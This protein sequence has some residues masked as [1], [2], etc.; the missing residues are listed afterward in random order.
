MAKPNF[1][2]LKGFTLVELSIVLVIFGLIVG[3]V[4]AGQSLI[5]SAQLRGQISQMSQFTTAVSAFNT[6]FE[7][8]PGDFTNKPPVAGYLTRTQVAGDG[9]GNGLIES[10][11]GGGAFASGEM[12]IFWS[13]LSVA[14]LV[15]FTSAYDNS[16]A[17]CTAA[18]A[19][20][21]A[22]YLPK[23]AYGH[24]NKVAVAAYQ[25][26]N[27]YMVSALSSSD[28]SGVYSG[29]TGIIPFDAYT[30]DAKLDD[31]TPNTGT[32]VAVGA[33]PTDGATHSSTGVPSNCVDDSVSPLTY[34]MTITTY[35]CSLL[36]NM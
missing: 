35:E 11:C 33:T 36:H 14:G 6:K 27:L 30:I 9:D 5:K 18:D 2:T 4:L 3:G 13:D 22:T 19:T 26:I 8:V 21:L 29:V 28:G 24:G 25:G 31:G 15:N 23:A 10:I 32:V 7:A 20:Q 12:D 1:N 34:Q 17:T 16:G